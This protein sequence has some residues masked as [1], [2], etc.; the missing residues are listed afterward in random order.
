VIDPSDTSGQQFIDDEIIAADP[1]ILY[2]MLNATGGEHYDFKDRGLDDA[3]KDGLDPIQHRYRGSMA[4]NGKFGS[5]RDFGNGAAGLVAG[6]AG[7]SY[8]ES[9]VGFDGLETI[10][11]S[12]I[13]PIG[14]KPMPVII[15]SFEAKPT[16]LAQQLGWQIGNSMYERAA[17]ARRAA[18]QKLKRENPEMVY[19]RGPKY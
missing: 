17:A 13:V 10:Q 7:L 6:R 1:N 5:A 8:G 12:R 19:P 2:Y 16:R 14:G 11:K 15:P 3:V 9:R 4:S 18:F